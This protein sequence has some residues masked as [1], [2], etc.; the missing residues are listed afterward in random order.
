MVLRCELVNSLR[1]IHTRRK[2]SLSKEILFSC[3]PTYRVI[4]R[5]RACTERLTKSLPIFRFTIEILQSK[6]FN[7]AI[8]FNTFVFLIKKEYKSNTLLKEFVFSD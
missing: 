2:S 5:K 8:I 6:P 7:L 1:K 4:K 3:E